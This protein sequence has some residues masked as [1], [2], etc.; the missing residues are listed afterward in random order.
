MTKVKMLDGGVLVN[1]NQSRSRKA[2]RQLLPGSRMTLK[3]E[4]TGRP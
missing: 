4:E 2:R 1:E 3:A